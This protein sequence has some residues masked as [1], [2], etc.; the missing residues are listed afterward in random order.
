VRFK[1]PG[2]FNGAL[3]F[4]PLGKIEWKCWAP[5]E[6]RK[7]HFTFTPPPLAMQWDYILVSQLGEEG[8]LLQLKEHWVLHHACFNDMLCVPVCAYHLILGNQCLSKV[9]SLLCYLS[10]HPNRKSEK[11]EGPSHQR[12]S[13]LDAHGSHLSR[14]EIMHTAP[15][16]TCLRSLES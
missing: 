7:V 10:P 15:A 6:T 8:L 2:P 5:E 11:C 13:A 16:Q 14:H 9:A 4:S 12:F 1:F 3:F